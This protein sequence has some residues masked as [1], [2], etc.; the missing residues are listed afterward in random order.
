MADASNTHAKQESGLIEKLNEIQVISV[1]DMVMMTKQDLEKVREKMEA[2]NQQIH[3][4]TR[5]KNELAEKVKTM[6]DLYL[7]VLRDQQMQTNATREQQQI[8]RLM[9]R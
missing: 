9:Y 1:T 2:M 3:T 7:L 5:E 6:N 4:L 8:H